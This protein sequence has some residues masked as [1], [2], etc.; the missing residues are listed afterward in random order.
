MRKREH[1]AAEA[2]AVL[3]GAEMVVW[4]RGE[5]GVVYEEGVRGGREG[6]GEEG[7]VEGGLPGAEVEGFESAVGEV[8]VEGG[9][10]GAD[11]VLE[12]GEAGEEGGGVEGGGAH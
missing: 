2:V 1:T 12:E 4:V 7:G 9:G 6:G 10:D 5:G 3:Q 11:G 8:A